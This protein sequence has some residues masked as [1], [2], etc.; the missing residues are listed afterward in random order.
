MLPPKDTPTLFLELHASYDALVT[1][2][3]KNTEWRGGLPLQYRQ[4]DRRKD[5]YNK[6]ATERK[7]AQRNMLACR[8][9]F[10]WPA[11]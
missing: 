1:H 3:F 11:M 10:N 6:K 9:H 4:K 7:I 2:L 5:Y 8:Y